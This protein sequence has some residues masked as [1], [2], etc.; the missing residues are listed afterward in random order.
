M[1]TNQLPDERRATSTWAAIGVALVFLIALNLRPPLTSV[2]PLLPQIGRDESLSEAMQGLLGSLPLLAFAA[3]SPLVHHV[4]RRFGMERSILLALL[5]LAVGIF[6]RS[7]TGHVGLWVGTVV[8]GSAIAVGNVLVPTLVKRDYSSGISRATGIY[9][10]CITVGAAIASAVAVPMADGTTWRGAL[11][12]W[13]IP[14][15]AVAV[16]WAPR[17]FR[18]P[19]Q[20]ATAAPQRAAATPTSVWRQPTAWLVT[21]FMGLQSTSFYV[22]VTWLP[23]IGIAAGQTERQAGW[24]LFAFQIVGI[25]SA[26]VIPRLMRN[27]DS[28]VAAG[29]ASSAPLLAGTLGLLLLPQFAALWA[30]VAGLG[31]GASLVVALSL[32]SLRGRGTHETTRLSGMAQSLGYLFAALGPVLAG[33]LAQVTASWQAPLVF[34][35][36]LTATQLAVS[37]PAGRPRAHG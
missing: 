18:S 13:A 22:L 19:P 9:S 5:V 16:V 32:I 36:L 31:S 14:V 3:V 17:A 8:I 34:V 21:A 23:T 4:S 27:P 1:P 10:A 11:A 25:F 2:G 6:A 15:V 12:F 28:Q 26:L 20:S 29:V 24:Q 37:F 30:I 35:C 33:F 7:F